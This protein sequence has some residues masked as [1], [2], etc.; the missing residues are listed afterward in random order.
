MAQSDAAADPVM[1]V[2]AIK[3][4]ARTQAVFF[5]SLPPV[6]PWNT[7]ATVFDGLTASTETLPPVTQ[8]GAGSPSSEQ[9]TWLIH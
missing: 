8:V 4:A 9:Q 7:R 3:P 1:A 6:L 5:I 2:I